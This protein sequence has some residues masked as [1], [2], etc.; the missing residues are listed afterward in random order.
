MLPGAVGLDVYGFPSGS[1]RLAT[2]LDDED[3]FLPSLVSSLHI[4]TIALDSR[5]N[6]EG[7][8]QDGLVWSFSLSFSF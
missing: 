3:R 7:D 2:R 6:D 1:P 4:E 5:R 8:I